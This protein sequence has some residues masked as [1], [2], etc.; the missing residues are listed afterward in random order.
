MPAGNSTRRDFEQ[1]IRPHG[2]RLLGYVR[3]LLADPGDAPD[4][5]QAALTR[6]FEQ[7]PRFDPEASFK[8]WIY[9]FLTHEALNANR[10]RQ[11]IPGA[12]RRSTTQPPK[13]RR[14]GRT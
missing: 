11:R 6:A 12:P 1:R 13:G 3:R 9:Q 2:A 4:V 14:R 5:L 8:S 10:R 7:H